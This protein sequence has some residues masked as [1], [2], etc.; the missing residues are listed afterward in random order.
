MRVI[1][2][3]CLSDNYAYLVVAGGSRDAFVRQFVQGE[4]DGPIPFREKPRVF[5]LG[6]PDGDNA[7]RAAVGAVS[8]LSERNKTWVIR[9]IAA[10][11]L[12]RVSSAT[13]IG[14]LWFAT[15]VRED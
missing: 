12:H 7:W 6:R 10:R 1:P 9:A 11:P 4:T 15:G 5:V 3:P 14:I 13:E 8:S 2:V